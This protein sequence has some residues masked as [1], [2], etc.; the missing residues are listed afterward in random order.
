MTEVVTTKRIKVPAEPAMA[1]KRAVL[2]LRVSSV[3]Q[4]NT[5]YDPE[6][7]SIPAQ[8]RSCEAKA[9]QLG[10]EIVGEFVEPGRSATS[11]DKRVEFQAML[12][13][14]RTERD[15]DYVLVYKLSRMNR[16][17]VDDAIVLMTLRQHNVSLI[18]ATEH[19]DESPEGQLM[20]GILAAMNEFR[21]RGDGAD[22]S[23]KMGEKARRGGTLGRAPLGY[24]NVREEYEGREIRTVALDP[25]R[26]PILRLAFEL[27]A[28]GDYSI[29]QLA[30]V[31]DDRGLRTRPGRQPEGPI[32]TSTL[33]RLLQDRYYAGFVSY[34]GEEFQGRHEALVT[35]ELFQRVQEI[36]QSRSGR[37]VRQRQFHHYL[38]GSLWCG[39]CRDSGRESRIIIQRTA[40]RLG[41]E[42]FYFFCRGKQ[43][44]V[45]TT[46]Y[47]DIET[48]EE[49]IED[50]YSRLRVTPEFASWVRHQLHDALE[51]KQRSTKLRRD[52]IAVQID[53]LDR[54]EEHLLELVG[55]E[56]MPVMK[57]RARLKKIRDDRVK[58]DH[59]M[60]DIDSGLEVGARLIEA[61]LD[62][63]RDPHELYRRMGPEARRLLNQAVFKKLYVY[64][65]RVSDRTYQ[66][67]FDILVPANDEFEEIRTS[68]GTVSVPPE[69]QV[70]ALQ[71]LKAPVWSNGGQVGMDGCNSKVAVWSKY[72]VVEAMGLEPTTSTLQRSHSSQL[73]YA[74]VGGGTCATGVL[75]V[76]ADPR[77][78][79]HDGGRRPPGGPSRAGRPVAVAPRP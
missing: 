22:I 8:R 40:S 62:I 3:S 45:C 38:K 58:L 66:A 61:A 48:I 35:P 36:V 30:A 43:E 15:V 31:L 71:S 42:Y 50:E 47:L 75:T 79:L 5:D 26:A 25:D 57:V 19:I 73:S 59:E 29:S 74:P 32:S 18:S 64:E 49:K 12:E 51:D 78:G 13:R 2:Y 6:G 69:V 56:G 14:I 37:G 68:R 20:H 24:R 27:Y 63:A 54:R 39:Q 41:Y 55:D 70:S 67:P 10:I 77:R 76:P 21:S 17:R 16:N 44:K 9:K 4:V 46:R 11:M 53:R 65:D 1:R 28:T 72:E 60:E 7:L 34:K 52:D 23:Y 33:A